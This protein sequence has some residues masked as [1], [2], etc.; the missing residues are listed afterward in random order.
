[1]DQNP[2]RAPKHYGDRTPRPRL[3]LLLNAI[4]LMV[5]AALG[6][7]AAVQLFGGLWER[8]IAQV[9]YGLIDLPLGVFLGY[10]AVR[11]WWQT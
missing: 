4:L 11:P 8:A 6:L 9:L 2:Y 1:M 7:V 3:A 5:S 10:R